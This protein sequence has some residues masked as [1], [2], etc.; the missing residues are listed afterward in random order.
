MVSLMTWLGTAGV[1]QVLQI[2]PTRVSSTCVLTLSQWN[3]S[4]TPSEDRVVA[5]NFG[6]QQLKI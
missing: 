5:M 2:L 3:A 4:L 6:G 1:A